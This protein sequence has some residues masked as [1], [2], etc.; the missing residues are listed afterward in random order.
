[1]LGLWSKQTSKLGQVGLPQSQ[2]RSLSFSRMESDFYNAEY[3]YLIVLFYK[4]FRVHAHVGMCTCTWK[5]EIV[6]ERL[7]LLLPSFLFFSP[8]GLVS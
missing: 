8:F 7:P 6:I 1:M 3:S 2:D 5:A 4:L